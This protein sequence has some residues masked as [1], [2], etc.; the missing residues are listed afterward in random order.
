MGAPAFLLLGVQHILTGPD[1]L[2]FV[3]GLLLLVRDRWMLLKTV[4]AFTVAHS[5]TL[6][7][8]TF[9]LIPLPTALLNALVALSIL[10][11]APEI[12]RAHGAARA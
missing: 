11:L 5:L 7:A 9:G 4:T 8:A 2:L 3:L 10:F 1:H 6:A 12:V